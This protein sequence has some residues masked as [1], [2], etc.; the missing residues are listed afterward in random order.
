MRIWGFNPTRGERY[1]NYTNEIDS[2]Q[3][4]DETQTSTYKWI[5][6]DDNGDDHA[7]VHAENDVNNGCHTDLICDPLKSLK[8]RLFQRLTSLTTQSSAYIFT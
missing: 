3:H 8:R 6:N 5:N 4:Y 7:D 1:K 2:T